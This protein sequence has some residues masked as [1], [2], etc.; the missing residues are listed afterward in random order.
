MAGVWFASSVYGQEAATREAQAQLPLARRDVGWFDPTRVD[1]SPGRRLR[2]FAALVRPLDGNINAITRQGYREPFIVPRRRLTYGEALRAIRASKTLAR[3][4][5]H[6]EEVPLRVGE[7]RELIERVPDNYQR[8]PRDPDLHP[9]LQDLGDEI[10][11]DIREA[12]DALD[13]PDVYYAGIDEGI[14]PVT[15]EHVKLVIW[16]MQRE[17]DRELRPAEG[18]AGMLSSLPAAPLW[19]LP[20]SIQRALA[21]RRRWR[22]QQWGI[23]REEWQ[24]GTWSLW[25]VPDDPEYV[26][27]RARR[28]SQL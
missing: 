3:A 19:E 28:L 13:D 7:C 16:A 9:A 4:R 11:E 15:D 5:P 10:N 21:E 12:L 23:G 22:F 24:R 27:R 17:L 20:W 1:T 2:C 25:N 14:E 6:F 18:Q 26:P 8:T